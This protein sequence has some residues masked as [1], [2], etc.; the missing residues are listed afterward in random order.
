MKDFLRAIFIFILL[1]APLAFSA[2]PTIIE[3]E[4]FGSLLI[5]THQELFFN[6]SSFYDIKDIEKLAKKPGVFKPSPKAIYNSG[7]KKGELWVKGVLWNKTAKKID[8]FLSMPGLTNRSVYLYIKKDGNW[9]TH[10]RGLKEKRSHD[11]FRFKFP[12]FYIQAAP[13]KTPYFAVIRSP[14]QKYN[15]PILRDKFE[16]VSA[17]ADFNNLV[18]LHLGGFLFILVYSLLDL[19]N[20]PTKE[21]IYY[22]LFIISCLIT[23]SIM[24]G[25]AQGVFGDEYEGNAFFTL[26]ALS[27]AIMMAAPIMF[28][29]HLLNLDT[30]HKKLTKTMHLVALSLIINATALFAISEILAAKI[31]PFL[32]VGMAIPLMIY[33]GFKNW[34]F[35]QAKIYLVGWG[36]FLAGF[37]YTFLQ[38]FGVVDYGIWSM[39]APVTGVAIKALFFKIGL[40]IKRQKESARA[41]EKISKLNDALSEKV[42]V[43]SS[44][45]SGLAHEVNNP[46]MI[47]QAANE[48]LREEFKKDGNETREKRSHQ[49]EK[50]LKRIAHTVT[51]IQVFAG[52]ENVSSSSH[53]DIKN[54]IYGIENE[55]KVSFTKNFKGNTQ[56]TGRVEHVRKALFNLMEN[57]VIFSDKDPSHLEV[58][59]I[60][61]EQQ[62]KIFIS[63]SGPKIDQEIR[64][65]IFEPF[66]QKDI[67]E[68]RGMGLAT[69]KSIALAHNGSLYL[70]ENKDYTTFCMVLQAA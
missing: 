61:Q 64:N 32:F 1:K 49:I 56:M 16:V 9:I 38:I 69:A 35:K 5:G 42:S 40:N 25:Y 3:K 4:N 55:L 51:D 10:K 59:S 17:V 21:N 43:I 8:T 36:V 66:Y 47:I 70:E 62:I 20:R 67:N 11:N 31:R 54:L 24:T 41:Q 60:S 18:S 44:V 53:F 52:E 27:S 23:F 68:K 34:S 15:N 14:V 48:I 26:S 30:S 57:A 45:A 7:L 19:K 65:R 50:S 6:I 28:T 29:I 33:A 39:L 12:G 22:V 63:N 37:S 58:A 2:S 46:L 13:G